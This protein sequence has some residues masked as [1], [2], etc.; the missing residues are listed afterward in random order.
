MIGNQI[1]SVTTE[2]SARLSWSQLIKQQKSNKK[3]A[4]HGATTVVDNDMN[5]IH[6]GS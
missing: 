2:S 5:E 1:T 3:M 6:A 4:G